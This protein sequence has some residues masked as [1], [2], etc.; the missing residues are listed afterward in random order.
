MLWFGQNHFVFPSPQWLCH[1]II[2]RALCPEDHPNKSVP[3]MKGNGRFESKE[4][5]WVFGN[6]S[7]VVVDV[8]T[9]LELCYSCD[10]ESGGNSNLLDSTRLSITFPTLQM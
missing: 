4:L 3:R 1:N 8:L 9:K 7:P 5:R 6:D 10:D 2:G